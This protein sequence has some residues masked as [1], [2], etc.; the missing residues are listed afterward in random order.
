[1]WVHGFKHPR[2]QSLPVQQLMRESTLV[3]IESIIMAV[4]S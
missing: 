2:S 4:S 1:L 3:L